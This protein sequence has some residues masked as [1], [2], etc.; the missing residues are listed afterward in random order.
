MPKVFETSKFA[1]TQVRYNEKR[2]NVGCNYFTDWMYKELRITSLPAAH[3]S[4]RTT[5]QSI[6]ISGIWIAALL[7]WYSFLQVRTDKYKRNPIKSNS[8]AVSVHVGSA[9]VLIISRSESVLLIYRDMIIYACSIWDVSEKPLHSRM[10]PQCVRLKDTSRCTR[11]SSLLTPHRLF[12]VKIRRTQAHFF[13]EFCHK[14]TRER[15]NCLID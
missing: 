11:C 2:S 13:K 15:R 4:Q 10:T 8:T 12:V 9:T 7:L 6:I 1:N 14:L 5:S 3:Y